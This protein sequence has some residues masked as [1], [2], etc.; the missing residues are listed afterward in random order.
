MSAPFRFKR[1][2]V[3]QTRAA[4]K[5]CT[6]SCLFGA[7]AAE[8]LSK[9]APETILDIGTGTG[10]LSLMAAQKTNARITGIEIDEE[11]CAEAQYNFDSSP[12]A[13]RLELKCG[14]IR[15]MKDLRPADAIICNPPFYKN[16]LRSPDEKRNTAMHG[17]TLTFDALADITAA[18]LTE[19]GY[20]AFLI[21]ATAEQTFHSA[22]EK[23]ALHLHSSIHVSHSPAH[24]PNRV[25]L[26]YTRSGRD[27]PAFDR[28]DIRTASGEYTP[29]FKKVLQEFYLAF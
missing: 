23:H 1:F 19:D 11:A 2:T 15:G 7:W 14:D 6:D 13:G 12:F 9:Q 20:A 25:M 10:L 24:V 17:S 29:E 28:L 4:M 27:A 8:H 26:L 21:P 5:V 3:T 18:L 16:N 22:F